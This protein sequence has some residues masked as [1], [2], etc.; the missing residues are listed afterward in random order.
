I[1][2]F[3]RDPGNQEEQLE[4]FHKAINIATT[5]LEN[6]KYKANKHLQAETLWR[7]GKFFKHYAV[8]EEYCAVWK[9]RSRSE[10]DNPKKPLIKYAVMPNPEGWQVISID[11][12]TYPLPKEIVSD[13]LVF[14]HKGRFIAI[15]R[16]KEAALK[17]A[18]SLS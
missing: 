12:Y 3:N 1:G 11:N 5:I 16:T 6:E 8:F 15:F 2:G 14:A 13:D 4:Q 7:N 10:S 17:L 9:N 18:E